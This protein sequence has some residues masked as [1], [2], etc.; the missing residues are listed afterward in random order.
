M[1]ATDQLCRS[2]LDLWW[3]FDPAAASRAGVTQQDG[4]LGAYDA[5]SLRQQV[6]ALKAIAGAA[7]EL[8]VDDTADE[9]DRTALLDHLRV[10]LF[11]FE[12]EHPWQRNPAL[13]VEH[14]YRALGVLLARSDPNAAA[15]AALERL[16]AAPGFLGA[17]RDTLQKPPPVLV[18]TALA[19]LAAFAPLLDQTETRFGAAWTAAPAEAAQA[20][21]EARS[22]L[23]QFAAALRALP[24]DPDPH[25][26]AVG[27]D[28]VDRRLHYEHAS[29]HNSAELHRGALRLVAETE[30]ELDALAAELDPARSWAE[31]YA[32]LWNEA[33]VWSELASEFHDALAGNARILSA[34]G[35]DCEAPPLA[36]EPEHPVAAVLEPLASYRAAGLGSPAAVLLGDA[37][38]ALL[39]WPAARLGIPGAHQ[40]R[41]QRDTLPGLVRRHIAATSTP[42]GWSLYAADLMAELGLGD[43]PE[44]RLAERVLFLRDVQLALVDLGFHT[45]Q[46]TAAEAVAQLTAGVPFGAATALADLRRIACRP[47]AACAALLGRQELR[48][49]R[50]DVADARGAEFSLQEFH[51]E[52]LSYGGLPVPLIRWGMGLDG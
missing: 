49:L 13:W 20:L 43:D 4:R 52:V 45:R 37:D 10:L 36:L 11:R 48:R 44:A 9:I 38:L 1:A 8:E 33:P 39:P 21:A 42:L 35:L 5:D 47:T 19:Q 14:L 26:G 12:H 40:H 30:A 18:D 41:T 7:E 23:E 46:L 24:V 31:L 15:D 34:H 29:I 32:K 51:G 28:E 17:A 2:F 50:N 22:A 27:E 16:R 6:A 25:A 3:H